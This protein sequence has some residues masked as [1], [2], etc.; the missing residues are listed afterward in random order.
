MRPGRHEIGYR[1]TLR[2]HFHRGRLIGIR[3][4][5]DISCPWWPA[6][7]RIAGR[8]WRN[9]MG[10]QTCMVRLSRTAHRDQ[11]TARAICCYGHSTVA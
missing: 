3:V 9:H 6:S 7:R 10:V 5:E 4:C 1:E 11:Y 8:E 2:I